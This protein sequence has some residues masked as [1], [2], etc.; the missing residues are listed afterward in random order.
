[1]QAAIVRNV[2]LDTHILVKVVIAARK[3]KARAPH[4]KHS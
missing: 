2:Y 4:F 3:Y 1:M